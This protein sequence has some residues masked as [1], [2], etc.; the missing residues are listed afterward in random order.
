MSGDTYPDG[1]PKPPKALVFVRPDPTQFVLLIGR[2]G[3]GT[4]TVLNTHN[5]KPTGT[6]WASEKDL[7]DAGYV[8]KDAARRAIR[9]MAGKAKVSEDLVLQA[10]QTLGITE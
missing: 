9:N 10:L 1:A 7:N 2:T 3:P 4:G 6:E 8:S 5:F